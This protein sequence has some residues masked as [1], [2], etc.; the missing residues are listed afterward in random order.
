MSATIRSTEAGS[1][2]PVTTNEPGVTHTTV[3]ELIR[4]R[5][6]LF[7]LTWRDVTIRYKQTLLGATWA[8]LQPLF[9]MIVFTVFFGRLAGIPSDGIPYPLF[10][11]AALLPWTYFS[12]ATLAAGNSLVNNTDLITKVYFP[13]MIIPASTVVSGLVDFAIASVLM[14]ALL[15]YYDVPPDPE[16]LVW[17]LAIGLVVVLALGAGM[18]LSAL[19]VAYRDVKHALP[20]AFQILLFLTPIIYPTTLVP[21]RYRFL[22]ALNPLTGI[23]ETC[24]AALLPAHAVDWSLFG[25][26]A[27]V[28]ALV[29]VAGALY[30]RSREQTFADIV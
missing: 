21:E 10:S 3:R 15:V 24:R 25:T 17:P 11:Y 22:T 1:A 27:L 6:L 16:L 26:S 19:N 23:I 28:T 13:R 2:L 5:E 30:F 18:F 9:T 8:V 7:F 20:F 4:Y 29:F 14:I 12:T